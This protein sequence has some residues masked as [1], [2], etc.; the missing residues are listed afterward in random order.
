[1][2]KR[3]P[4]DSESNGRDALGVVSVSMREKGI[5]I[6]QTCIHACTCKFM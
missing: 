5:Y 3:A 6:N 2:F 4:G 1:M